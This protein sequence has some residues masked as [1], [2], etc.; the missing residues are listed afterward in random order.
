MRA[1]TIAEI[2]QRAFELIDV[3]G[4]HDLSLAAIAKGMGMSAPGLYRYFASRD[5]LLASLARTA[6]DQLSDALEQAAATVA[7][8]PPAERLRS[9]AVAYRA[10]ALA[11][12]KRYT[13]LFGDRPEDLHDTNEAITA[14]SRG[15]NVLLAPIIELHAVLGQPPA[16]ELDHQLCRWSARHD[17]PEASPAALGLAVLTWTRLHGVVGLEIAG[18]FDDMQ[19]DAGLLLDAEI[20][21]VVTAAATATVPQRPG[22]PTRR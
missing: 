14:A 9:A 17:Q 3:H 21:A 7:I 10:W 12:P 22:M 13:M 4:A 20:A 18:V 8:A 19:L 16:T 2:E 11:H 6:Y 1:Q 15:M 5:A